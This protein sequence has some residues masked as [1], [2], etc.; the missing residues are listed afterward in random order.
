MLSETQHPLTVFYVLKQTRCVFMIQQP[1]KFNSQYI[2]PV[3]FIVK[4]N[5]TFHHLHY[6]LASD[7]LE[8]NIQS[9]DNPFV[10]KGA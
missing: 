1:V 5:L 6:L 4:N 3:P 2:N 8:Y 9:N 10:D 7:I